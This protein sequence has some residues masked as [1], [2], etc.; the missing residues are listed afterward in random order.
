MLYVQFWAPD[1]G[2][3]TRQERLTEIN[4]ETLHLVGCTQRMYSSD[5]QV[6]MCLELPLIVSSLL[7]RFLQVQAMR[8]VK[9]A[10]YMESAEY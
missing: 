1:D 8:W 6:S 2:R 7:H 9:Y 5:L 4:C 10:R 3:K